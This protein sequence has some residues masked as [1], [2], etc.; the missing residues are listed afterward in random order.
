MSW[1]PVSV[2]VEPASEPV[3]LVQAKAQCRVDGTDSDGLFA[4]YIKSARILVEQSCG[5]RIMPQTLQAKCSTWCDLEHLPA[6]PLQSI[7]S[8]TYLDLDGNTQTLS[9]DVYQS[10]L[11]GLQPS[12]RLKINQW[13]PPLLGL[14]GPY[15]YF[16]DAITVTMTAGYATVPETLVQA[17]LMLISQWYDERSSIS[18]VRQ[19]VTPDGSV[20]MLPNTVDALLSN[21]RRF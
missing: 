13:W 10:V 16:P 21:Y 18:S 15:N 12:I 11:E 3:S 6:A 7:T 9:T 14:V 19:S 8:I 1:L 20:P 17:M 5:L 4:S 2:T